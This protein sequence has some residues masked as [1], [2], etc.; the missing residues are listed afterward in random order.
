[1]KKSLISLLIIFFGSGCF[2][3]S[4][5]LV[6][7]VSE[8]NAV[9]HFNSGFL[10]SLVFILTLINFFIWHRYGKDEIV[11]P[12]VNFYPPKGLDPAEA[13]LAYKGKVSQKGIAATVICLA[14][15]GYL[16]IKD[17]GET[18][19]IKNNR[20]IAQRD[21]TSSEKDI[22]KA[23]YPFDYDF[24]TKEELQTSYIFHDISQK[25]IEKLD[26]KK[27]MIFF[28]ETVNN[29][30]L[31][32][33]ILFLIL[34]VG[35]AIF[36]PFNSGFG[37]LGNLFNIVC[38]IV[39]AVCTYQLPKRT[40]IGNRLL[41][42]LLGLKQF[43][44]VAK[45]HEIQMLVE[46]NPNYFYDVLPYAY[47][48]DVSSQWIEKFKNIPEINLK[49]EIGHKFW[50]ERTLRDMKLLEIVAQSALTAA[51]MVNYESI[52]NGEDFS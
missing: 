4:L 27:E 36:Y 3:D 13:E 24:V 33:M 19:T 45:K 25:V 21:L 43:I 40:G 8:S 20:K 12:V 35:L 17:E 9:I 26:N 11:I 41:G 34:T 51:G 15:K 48:L 49:W 6:S 32:L 28:K 47:V 44:E 29:T 39:S 16:D 22:L 42:Q 38:I 23:L 5:P 1:M 52:M 2:A 18:F 30:I 50:S 7:R 31:I 10:L 46:K 14:S 37:I